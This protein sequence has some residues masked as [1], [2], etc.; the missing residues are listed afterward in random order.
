MCSVAISVKVQEDW[1]CLCWTAHC[2]SLCEAG[3]KVSG[4][5][6]YLCPLPKCRHSVIYQDL[7]TFFT[8]L[9]H[10]KCCSKD[11]NTTPVYLSDWSAVYFTQLSTNLLEKMATVKFRFN[12][13][14]LSRCRHSD[15][16]VPI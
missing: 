10:C 11:P 12:A 15:L 14:L 2:K 8:V 1:L 6:V 4:S 3:N 13:L 16:K 5:E 9:Y 7:A